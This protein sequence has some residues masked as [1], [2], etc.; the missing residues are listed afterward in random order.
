M[1]LSLKYYEKLYFIL[2]LLLLFS[3]NGKLLNTYVC[4]II[5]TIIILIFLFRFLCNTTYLNL[6]FSGITLGQIIIFLFIFIYPLYI[7]FYHPTFNF[8]YNQYIILGV[9]FLP[10]FFF[11][12]I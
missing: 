5:F 1:K 12:R 7:Y 8:D 10:L 6:H 4:F 11:L 9:S 2:C 3:N